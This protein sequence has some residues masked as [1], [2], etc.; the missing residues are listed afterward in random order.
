MNRTLKLSLFIYFISAATFGEQ[1]KPVGDQFQVNTYTTDEQSYGAVAIDSAGN[2]V[3]VWESPGDADGYGIKGSRYDSSGS[4]QGQ[5]FQV[6]TDTTGDQLLPRVARNP[7]GEFVVAWESASS[8]G[9]DTDGF[10]IQ[11]RRFNANGTA[12]AQFQIN[13]DTSG[14]QR[15]PSIDIA[16]GGDFVIVWD[17]YQG[18]DLTDI[19]GQ[20]YLSSGNPT[21]SEFPVHT[22]ATGYQ[23]RPAVAYSPSGSFLV[24]WQSKEGSDYDIFGRRFDSSGSPLGSEFPINMTTLGDQ[25]RPSLCA[26]SEDDYI[27]TWQSDGNCENAAAFAPDGKIRGRRV[28]TKPFGIEF[29]VDGLA[30]SN[31]RNSDIGC[32][33]NPCGSL[34]RTNLAGE[35][36]VFVAWQSDGQDGDGSGVFA[37]HLTANG[38]TL[39]DEFQLNSYATGVQSSPTLALDSEGFMVAIWQSSEST[40]DNS[41]ASIQ[42]QRFDLPQLIFSNGFESGDLS[43]WNSAAP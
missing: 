14:N 11:G 28:L 39:G 26:T 7:C 21:G 33:Q 27:V 23:S 20:R 38:A 29:Q 18:L 42:G 13:T 12:Q 31:K 15:N 1:P 22:S 2:F 41:G 40:D 34:G 32:P 24:V 37:R 5:E 30:G 19:V 43:A 35:T 4:R 3:V 16:S 25:C 9:T 8:Q 6:N 17:S 36:T 10:S